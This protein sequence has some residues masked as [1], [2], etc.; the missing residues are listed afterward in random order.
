MKRCGTCKKEKPYE[1]FDGTRSSCRVC[2]NKYFRK[3]KPKA[4]IKG[5][6][7]IYI[8]EAQSLI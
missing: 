7:Y 5:R 1:D 3:E 4:V 8:P 6:D 2:R